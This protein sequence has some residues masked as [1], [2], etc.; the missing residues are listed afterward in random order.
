LRKKRHTSFFLHRRRRR[1]KFSWVRPK[2]K[3]N[4]LLNIPLKA[5]I[6][7]KAHDVANSTK[8]DSLKVNDRHLFNILSFGRRFN[9][10]RE[11]IISLR[12]K[13]KI[14]NRD[15]FTIKGVRKGDMLKKKIIDYKE[16]EKYA[17]YTNIPG[18]VNLYR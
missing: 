7:K 11:S 1:V 5:R 18:V 10:V 9:S 14:L 16:K 6:I 12:H 17:Q 13:I 3:S 2:K 8:L 15:R 4:A